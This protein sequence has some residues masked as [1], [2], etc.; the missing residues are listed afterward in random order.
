MQMAASSDTPSRQPNAQHLCSMKIIPLQV[1]VTVNQNRGSIDFSI[2]LLGFL[3]LSQLME[4]YGSHATHQRNQ[5]TSR[6]HPVLT[7]H[8]VVLA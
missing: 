2:V 6:S 7:R 8:Q 3:G 5:K 4:G 1:I